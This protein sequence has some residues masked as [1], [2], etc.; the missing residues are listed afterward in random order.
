MNHK[1]IISII[2]INILLLSILSI[3]PAESNEIEEIYKLPYNQEIILPIFKET[4]LIKKQPIDVRINFTYYCWALNEKIHSIRTIYKDSAGQVIELN[5]GQTW[6]EVL[7][8]TNVVS[9]SKT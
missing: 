1:I 5:P 2:T 3:N 6:I 7:P 9:Y 4:E 8:S